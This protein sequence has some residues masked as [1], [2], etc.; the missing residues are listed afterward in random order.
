MT[1]IRYSFNWQT[2]LLCESLCYLAFGYKFKNNFHAN[3]PNK[4]I[5]ANQAQLTQNNN[6]S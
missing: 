1:Q 3:Y 2:Q 6:V 5:V 4:N